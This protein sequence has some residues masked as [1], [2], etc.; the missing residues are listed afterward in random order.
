MGYATPNLLPAGDSDFEG[1]STTW[2]AG[3]NTTAALSTTAWLTGAKSLRL[4]ATAAGS[5]VAT[6]PRM[7]ATA[8]LQYITDIPLRMVSAHTGRTAVATI[9]WYN[10]ASGGSVVTTSTRTINLGSAAGWF[11]DNY[12]T[13]IATAPALTLS[14]TIAVTVTGLNAAE[15]IYTDR[16]FFGLTD[17]V[18]GNVV[19]YNTYSV[20]QDT[21]GWAATNATVSRLSTV[22]SASDSGMYALGLTS[23]AA[24]DMQATTVAKYPV[25]ANA[26]Y[27]LTALT[28]SPSATVPL[29]SAIR[30]YDASN[31]LISTESRTGTSTTSTSITIVVGTAPVGATS[32]DVSLTFT[33]PSAGQTV[34]V[35]EIYLRV[36]PNAVGNLLKYD[37]F[38]TESFLPAWT[39]DGAS[40]TRGFF[41]SVVTDG[42]Y[43]LTLAPTATG[44]ITASLD[45]LV[46][47]TAGTTYAVS[48]TVFAHNPGPGTTHTSKRVRVDWYNALGSLLEVDNPDQF[49]AA[50]VAVGTFGSTVTE[51]RKCPN[52]AA[53]AR[54]MVQID[55]TD[56]IVDTYYVDNISFAPATA[57][58]E[59]TPDDTTGSISLLVNFVPPTGTPSFI[60]IRRMDED[61]NASPVRGY[62]V[63]FEKAP[64]TPG[65]VLLEDYEAP[66]GQSVWYAVEF[67]NSDLSASSRVFTRTVNSPVLADENYVW[68]KA[69]GLPALN[70]QVMME[71]PVKWSR[72]AR[73][74]SYAI[75]GRKN[76]LT[77][78]GV[79]GGRTGSITVLVW[80]EPSNAHFNALLDNGLTALIQAMPGYGIDGNLYVSIG[81]SEVE[82]LTQNARDD[83]W[84]WT[85]AISE[86]DRP[87]GGLQGSALATWQTVNDGNA[88]WFAVFDGHATWTDVLIGG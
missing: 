46:P 60:T 13:L 15:L 6:S 24:G 23:V 59:I 79:R 57:E 48:A 42:Y 58:Y 36:A 74:S 41:V 56:T 4:T 45:R 68:F 83:G 72:A 62:G 81:D 11:S 5:V 73:S 66:L 78:A 64:Y 71:A 27:R 32:A 34:A 86:T 84:R 44:T 2:T 70:T 40:A 3:A 1:A 50:T 87:A 82:P 75:V 35:D 54:V 18:A 51:T 8:G 65:A 7:L 38:S 63:D 20:E 31:A 88:D 29:T 21:S 55:H 53:F 80:D 25:T 12:V 37:E 22:L 14:A 61:G 10:A 9:T 26:E 39:V 67:F 16:V 76:P 17:P 28:L 33:M 85:L 49:Y 47:V 69:P 19:D 43:A 52:G 30:W 77:V